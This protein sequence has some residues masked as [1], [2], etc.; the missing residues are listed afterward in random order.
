MN[1]RLAW[2]G[3]TTDNEQRD[4]VD[5]EGT[6]EEFHKADVAL[7]LFLE[8]CGVEEIAEKRHPMIILCGV[9]AFVIASEFALVFFFMGEHLGTTDAF[10]ASATAIVFIFCSS[11]G[12]A[13]SHANTSNNLPAWR[14]VL[15]LLGI[16]IS[17]GIFLY[18]IGLLS[19]WRADTVSVGLEVVLDGYRAM[20]NLPVFITAL[21]NVFGFALLMYEARNHCWPRFWGFRDIHQRYLEAE[22]RF[23]SMRAENA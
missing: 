10:Y 9:A 12:A 23:N 13:F 18:G 11:F 7:K 15:G 19:G 6:K 1:S 5:V 2:L 4:I 22:K 16:L 20:S 14:R 17:V 8:K 3:G 21:V